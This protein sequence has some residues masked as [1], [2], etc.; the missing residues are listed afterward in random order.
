MMTWGRRRRVGDERAVSAP[1]VAVV[2]PCASGKS[3]LVHALRDAGIDAYAC[4][5]E[6]SGVPALWLH[7]GADLLIAL[8]VD[9]ATIRQRRGEEWPADLYA[10]QCERLAAA[11]AA[12]DLRIDTGRHDREVALA[13]ALATVSAWRAR[14]DGAGLVSS[15]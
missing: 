11:Y 8:E 2:G 14:G 1:R 13:A 6:H 4:A 12:A 10:A 5:Q 3:T 9:L 7:G 15:A